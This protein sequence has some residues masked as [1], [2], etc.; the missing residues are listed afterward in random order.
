[1]AELCWV[2]LCD[3]LQAQRKKCDEEGDYTMEEHQEFY[4]IKH[5]APQHRQY[6]S[7]EVRLFSIG[8]N[9]VTLFMKRSEKPP[10]GKLGRN[11]LSSVSFFPCQGFGHG[12]PSQRNKQHQRYKFAKATEAVFEHQ[13]NKEKA[14]SETAVV[15]KDKHLTRQRTTR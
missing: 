7:N 15:E 11:Y 4:D 3:F 1:M 5:T 6:L 13:F 14:Q 8:S 12:T 2:H 10:D 9:N